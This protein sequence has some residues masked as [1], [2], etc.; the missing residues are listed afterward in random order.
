MSNRTRWKFDREMRRF[1]KRYDEF[2]ILLS[3][4][5]G[6]RSWVTQLRIETDLGVR[7]TAYWHTLPASYPEAQAKRWASRRF[8]RWCREK[9]LVSAAYDV[10]RRGLEKERR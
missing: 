3:D 8:S 7:W 4:N 9:R 1:E 6:C 10:V 5:E 2:S